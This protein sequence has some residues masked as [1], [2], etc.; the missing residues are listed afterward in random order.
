MV[1]LILAPLAVSR[2]LR[3]WGFS[4]R[5]EPYKGAITNWGFFLVTYTIVGL[6]RA[7]FLDRP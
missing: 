2:L 6:N 1:E 5:L 7:V 3:R 4:D